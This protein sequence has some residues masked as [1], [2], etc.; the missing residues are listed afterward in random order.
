MGYAKIKYK[1]P[2][3]TTPMTNPQKLSRSFV[4]LTLWP[5]MGQACDKRATALPQFGQFTISTL[6]MSKAP[7]N[8]DVN[9]NA[10]LYCAQQ[11][12]ADAVLA[13]GDA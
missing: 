11:K 6:D 4:L 7:I 5:Q 1:T 12:G 8:G 9:H 10:R 2:I 13:R 3:K